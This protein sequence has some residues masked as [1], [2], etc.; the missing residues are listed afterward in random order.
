M[1]LRR[2]LCLSFLMYSIIHFTCIAP[3]PFHSAVYFLIGTSPLY[4]STPSIFRIFPCRLSMVETD[5]LVCGWSIFAL[6]PY[7]LL[8]SVP[9]LFCLWD[10][11]R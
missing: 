7:V 11:V 1:I 4:I 10:A 5:T 9:Y 2:W 6:L 8:P 3:F